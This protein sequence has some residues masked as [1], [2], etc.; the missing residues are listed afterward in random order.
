IW[1]GFLF[2]AVMGL[3]LTY[4]DRKVS[5]RVQYRIGPGWYQPFADVLKLLAKQ[6]FLP[7]GGS[8]TIFLLGPC[9]AITSVTIVGMMLFSMNLQPSRSF[10]GDLIVLIY[11]LALVPLGVILGASASRNPV[12]A[13]GA[14]REMTL[15]FAYELPL[16]IALL[17]PVVQTNSLRIGTMVLW[18]QQHHAVLYSFSGAIAAAIALVCMQAK[19]GLPPFDIAEAEQ[20]LMAGP[21]VEYSG[22]ALALYRLARAMLTLLLPIFFITVFWGGIA[23]VWAFP[24]FLLIFGLMVLA[25]NTNPR[26]RIDQALRLFWIGLSPVAAAAVV[27]AL[28]GA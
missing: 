27:L 15:Y 13:V 4:I 7:Q 8:A 18:Q 28:L 21:L 1:P 3:F 23:N 26:I 22:A 20:E 24:K 12:A 19:L 2:C 17:V 9:L 6:T 11:L 10:A 25:K 5:A 14:S 16:V